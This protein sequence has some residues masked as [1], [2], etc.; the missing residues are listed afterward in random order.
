MV[1]AKISDGSTLTRIPSKFK[2]TPLALSPDEKMIATAEKVGGFGEIQLWRLPDGAP[3][4]S[5]RGHDRD[6]FDL[7]FSRDSR[8]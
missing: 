8:I 1:V 4:R 6:I 3:I 2:T 5:L 7:E